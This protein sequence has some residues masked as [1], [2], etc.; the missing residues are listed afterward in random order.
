MSLFLAAVQDIY[1]GTLLKVVFVRI[2][3]S[4][5]SSSLEQPL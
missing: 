1:G 2:F 3:S 5:V 4:S